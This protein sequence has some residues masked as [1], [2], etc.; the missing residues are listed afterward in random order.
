VGLSGVGLAG[1]RDGKGTLTVDEVTAILEGLQVSAWPYGRVVAIQD[2][3][4]LASESEHSRIEA[5]RNLLSGRMGEL[6][7]IVN[8][9]PSARAASS[10]VWISFIAVARY[11][12]LALHLS[13]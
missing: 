11:L 2:N 7:V 13:T 6:G 9:G 1:V 12:K 10:A 5:S 3:G 8:F 4:V